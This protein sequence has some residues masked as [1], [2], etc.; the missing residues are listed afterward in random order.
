MV[1]SCTMSSDC[2]WLQVTFCS[3]VN[4]TTLFSFLQL[5][6]HENGRSLH[7]MK[8]FVKIQLGD[9]MVVNDYWT[10][11]S[12]SIVIDLLA[13]DKSWYSTQ[14]CPIIL[15]LIIHKNIS[16]IYVLF[17]S[18]ILFL[19]LGSVSSLYWRRFLSPGSVCCIN[20]ISTCCWG[21]TFCFCVLCKPFSS[22]SLGQGENFR[23]SF[24]KMM[25]WKLVSFHILKKI[26][27]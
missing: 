5:L 3:C 13:T 24:L 21:Y 2:V 19:F 27:Y 10:W 14:S 16:T 25:D 6:L 22:L 17:A 4:E 11:L 1:C 9:Q 23:K 26:N 20:K 15:L 8:I 12:Q 7:F 18:S